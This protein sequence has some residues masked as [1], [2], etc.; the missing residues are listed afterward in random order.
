M[1]WNLVTLN[2]IGGKPCSICKGK[3]HFKSW[4]Y[5]SVSGTPYPFNVI[6]TLTNLDGL[7]R[8][9]VDETNLYVQQNGRKFRTEKKEMR[10]LLGISYIMSISKLPTIKSC[11]E[12]GQLS[13]NESIRNVMVRSRFED[14]LWNIHFSNSTKDDKRDKGYKIRSH[15]NHFKS[16]CNTASNQYSQSVDEHIVKFKDR[17]SMKQYV[18]NNSSKW[19]LKFGVVVLMR[20][21][22]SINF[23]FT[24]VKNKVQKKIRDQVMFW[25]WLSPF[26]IVTVC[27]SL[28]V[29]LYWKGM[30]EMPVDRKMR[31]GDF[32]Y[33]DKVVCCK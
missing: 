18:K 1:R 13:G 29:K 33:S 26:K 11:W 21:D 3:M 28:I 27:V 30:L 7:V 6:S 24:W 20:Q 15:I 23:T 17:S 12:C 22:A 32:V 14:I 19:S 25:K 10:A 9:L 8:L 5:P 16:F 31:R 2:L 4:N